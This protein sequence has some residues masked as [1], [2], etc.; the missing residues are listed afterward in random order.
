MV[1]TPTILLVMILGV[2]HTGLY[3]GFG[4]VNSVQ[5]MDAECGPDKA[6]SLPLYIPDTQPCLGTVLSVPLQYIRGP[7]PNSSHLI[8]P[9]ITGGSV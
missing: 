5:G 2:L 7:V 1:S 3:L 9:D 4:V 8:N 6:C